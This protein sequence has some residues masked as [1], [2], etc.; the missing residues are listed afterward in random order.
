[1]ARM[2][3]SL[4]AFVW[5]TETV[6]HGW[7][8]GVIT[9]LYKA[10]DRTDCGNYRPITLLPTIGK[11]FTSIMAKRLERHIPLHDHQ[12]AFRR[13]RGTM[14]PLF[15]FASAILQRKDEDKRTHA[16]LLDLKKAYDKVWHAGLF[17]KLHHKGVRA[18]TWRL[19]WDMY[20]KTESVAALEGRHSEPFRLL[21]G[22]AQGDP[23]SCVLFNVMIDDLIDT[24]Q[25]NCAADGIALV[26]DHRQ[27]TLVAQGYADDVSSLSGTR[28]GLQRII[29]VYRSHLALWKGEVNIKKS[30]TMTFHAGGRSDDLPAGP[31]PAD[32]P[33]PWLWGDAALPHVDKVKYLGVVFTSDC[34][35]NEHA[36]Y[37][38]S[39]GYA[40]L[41]M[42]KGVLRN[43]HI[44]LPA[45]L[46]VITACIKPCVTYGMEV[47]APPDGRPAKAL[48]APMRC[49]LRT[50][51]GVPGGDARNLYPVHLM[52][53]D[54][55]IRP[56]A[57][58]NRAAH[59]RYWQRVRMMPASRLQH[60]ALSMLTPRH[61]WLKRVVRWRDEI[62]AADPDASIAALLAD[63]VPPPSPVPLEQEAP[64]R[65]P[66]RAINDGVAKGD[67]TRYLE[68]SRRRGRPVQTLAMRRAPCLRPQPYLRDQSFPSW[69]LFRCGRFARDPA[70]MPGASS[71]HPDCPDCGCSVI[72]EDGSLVDSA[73][74][75]RMV[76]HR[77]TSCAAN[78]AVCRWYHEVALRL[79]PTES[80][81]R[82]VVGAR[83]A[84]ALWRA[85]DVAAWERSC[86]PFLDHLLCPSAL[87]PA[88]D[89]SMLRLM[90]EATRLFLTT[91]DA[92]ASDL[93][94]A[95]LFGP[96][97]VLPFLPAGD[98]GGADIDFAD[99]SYWDVVSRHLPPVPRGQPGHEAE[100][101]WVRFCRR[102]LRPRGH[103]LIPD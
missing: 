28:A 2:L 69:L 42:W 79:A 52:H 35:W 83:S 61:P 72:P 71:E 70:G 99:A 34:T 100:A 78:A 80:V 84:C 75:Y 77:V 53:Y 67:T 93:P 74:S 90:L 57:S 89:P 47:W 88:G 36:A 81:A 14:D 16:F 91:V 95:G 65:T 50:A 62:V 26:P 25:T 23:M 8:Q 54:T 43:R 29:D 98:V 40:A 92:A 87:C 37:A 44:S 101:P 94:A 21:Q 60:R 66:N 39:K 63:Q 11:L 86:L 7:R 10:G 31:T 27:A 32:A 22:V 33:A 58:D 55:A 46:A 30:C 13:G 17:Y 15:V 97:P 4:Y 45:K 85:G 3:T 96:E 9:S 19:I 51:L 20:A 6:P 59:V 56:F 5:R 49:A 103:G 48:E 1:M 82:A 64:V 41:A 68:A 24:L 18:K 76:L 73:C 12:S 102:V 38:R